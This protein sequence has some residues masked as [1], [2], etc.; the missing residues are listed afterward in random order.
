MHNSG[1][2]VLVID[3]EVDNTDYTLVNSNFE[4]YPGE[5]AVLDVSLR[6]IAT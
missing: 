3:A 1:T 5:N 4:I 6:T 2:S